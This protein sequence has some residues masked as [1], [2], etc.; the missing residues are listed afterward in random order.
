[1]LN[2]GGFRLKHLS[3]CDPLLQPQLDQLVQSQTVGKVDRGHIEEEKPSMKELK[4]Q[5]V[6]LSPSSNPSSLVSMASENETGVN[7]L[8][9]NY[10]NQIVSLKKQTLSFPC[11][12]NNKSVKSPDFHDFFQ[13]LDYMKKYNVTLTKRSLASLISTNADVS[14]CFL[15]LFKAKIKTVIK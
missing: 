12:I 3:T 5:L 2:H 13:Y 7:H 4:E 15:V 6:L 1:M 8:G 9:H 10:N 11:M 14:G